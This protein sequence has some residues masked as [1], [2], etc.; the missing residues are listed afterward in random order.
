MG[1]EGFGAIYDWLGSGTPCSAFPLNY[2]KAESLLFFRAKLP[3]NLACFWAVT[4]VAGIFEEVTL[5]L[6]ASFFIRC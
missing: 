3:P 4:D 5:D 2:P 6:D 1:T